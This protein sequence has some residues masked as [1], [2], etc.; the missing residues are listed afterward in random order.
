M[1]TVVGAP[2]VAS[3]VAA[4]G[5][6]PA[7]A[8]LRLRFALALSLFSLAALGWWWTAGEMR[9]MDMGPWTGLGS[10]GWFVGVWLVMMAA[11]MLPSVAPTVALHARMTR[12]RSPLSPLA[13]TAGYL[14]VWTA[15]GVVAFALAAGATSLVGDALAWDRAGREL[16]AATLLGAAVYEVTPLKNACLGRCRSP[17]GF[18][19]G[20]WRDG[21]RGAVGMGARLGLWCLGC[22]WALMASLF[23]LGVMSITWMAVVAGV[24]ALEKALPWRRIATYGVAAGLLVAGLLLSVSPDALPG[25]TVPGAESTPMMSD[26]M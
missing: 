12:Q 14:L 16:A 19:L 2:A 13:F 20:T 9:G 10:L 7:V 22:C 21:P 15:A 8:A 24:I 6:S 1:T 23:A 18:L 5:L 4:S 25:L 17:L 11:M 3:S 26:G